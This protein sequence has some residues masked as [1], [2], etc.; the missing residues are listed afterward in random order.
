MK[1]VLFLHLHSDHLSL[2]CE[3]FAYDILLALLKLGK[4][5]Y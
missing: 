2:A 1:G 3:R 5:Q 4:L